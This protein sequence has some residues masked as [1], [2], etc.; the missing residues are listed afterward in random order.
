MPAGWAAL[1][2]AVTTPHVGQRAQTAPI[3]RRETGLPA[4]DD[5][6]AARLA[7]VTDRT[8]LGLPAVYGCVRVIAHTV[9][10]LPLSYSVG[11]VTRPLPEW[12]RAPETY[13]DWTTDQLVELW[14]ADL[15][16]RGR[17]FGWWTVGRIEPVD[18][19]A[20]TVT[21]TT[22]SRGRIRRAY[23]VDGDE[24]QPARWDR[25]GLVHM[26]LLQTSEYPGGI[27]PLQAA[28][29][30]VAG[31][32][33]TEAF[34]SSVFDRGTHSGGILETDQLLSPEQSAAWQTAWIEAR[35]A[36]LTPV[37]GSGLAYRND[38]IK[39]ADAQWLESRQWNSQEV[40]RMYG[41]PMR[42]LGLPSGDAT[43]YSTARDNDQTFL[44]SCVNGYTQTI[45]TGLSRL[46]G[47]GRSAADASRVSF[48][49]G[50]WLDVVGA[51]PTAGD[52]PPA[53]STPTQQGSS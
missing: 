50:A 25:T 3:S 22:G 1:A 41:V 44:R 47:P 4:I 23:L 39:P 13:S 30:S 7:G 37:L 12:L 34:A 20:V 43:T 18:P 35:K 17:A 42:Y 52:T 26:P 11:D 8:G 19:D 53:A 45:A 28:R 51:L 49:Y 6:L 15:A 10:Q 5:T 21:K 27:G 33:Q 24:V 16:T 48:D 9:E 32:A 2:D 14:T 38:L 31:Y 46:T 36:G 40:A 29:V